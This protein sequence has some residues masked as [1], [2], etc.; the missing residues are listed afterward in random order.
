MKKL[1]TFL[2]LI[3]IV[4][5]FPKDVFANGST[6]NYSSEEKLELIEK[7]APRIWF[8]NDEKYFP[9]SV[10]WSAQYMERYKPSGSNEYSLRTKESLSNPNGVLDFFRGDLNSAKIYAGWREAGPNTIDI[11]Y[12]VWYPYNRGKMTNNI[13]WLQSLIP[14]VDNGVGFGHH[15]GDWEGLQIRLVNGEPTQVDLRY[16]AWSK[17][18]NWSEFSKVENTH[19][20]TYSAQGSH[21]TWKDPGVHEYMDFVLDSLV[22][23]T[24]QGTAWDSWNVVEA[25]DFDL[26]EGLSGKNWPA[27]LSNDNTWT[28]PGKDPANPLSGGIN[29]WGNLESG[30]MSDLCINSGGPGGPDAGSNWTNEFGAP[31]TSLFNVSFKSAHNK[32]LVAEGNGDGEVN[33]DRNEVGPWEKFNLK[34]TNSEQEDGTGCIRSGDIVNIDTGSSYYLRATDD[35]LLDAEATVPQSWESFELINHT[36]NTG[37]LASG[38]QVSFKSSHGKYIV[39]ESDGDVHADRTAIGPWEKFIVNFH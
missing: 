34:V 37:C 29:R 9:S 31:V 35:G 2:S 24:S 22:D 4:S 17:K 15:V 10:E 30:C 20:V 8:D 6:I 13:D 19:I 39:A 11:N 5:V 21:G 3:L 28:E 27:W 18:Y 16:H 26:Q 32:Y 7:Y 33:A 1:I 14:F 38:D 23:I 25:Y 12:M 36:D